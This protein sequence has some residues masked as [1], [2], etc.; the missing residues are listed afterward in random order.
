MLKNYR[1]TAILLFTLS[2]LFPTAFLVGHPIHASES[3][4]ELPSSRFSAE[5][6][7]GFSPYTSYLSRTGPTYPSMNMSGGLRARYSLTDSFGIFGGMDI[8]NRGFELSSGK[9]SSPLFQDI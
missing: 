3:R 7:G 9:V 8:L 5:I 2:V 6:I 1:R 4:F